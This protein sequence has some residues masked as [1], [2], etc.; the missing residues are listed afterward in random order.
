MRPTARL[1]GVA[2]LFWIGTSAAVAAESGRLKSA[3]TALFTD[4]WVGGDAA[5]F[6]A[7]GHLSHAKDA[8]P[9]DAR[10]LY[11]YAL[12]QLKGHKF[13][14]ARAT[15][16]DLVQRFPNE[17]PARQTDVWLTA[18]LHDYPE[19]LTGLSALAARL[20]KE[21][22]ASSKDELAALE[23]AKFL[24]RM[25]GFLAGPAPDHLP[26][27]KV[28]DAEKQVKD[29]LSSGRRVAFE[30]GR[31]EVT[32]KFNDLQAEKTSTQESSKV[33]EAKQKSDDQA[34]IAGDRESIK[35]ERATLE[36]QANAAKA[37]FDTEEKKLQEQIKPLKT[38]YDNLANRARPLQTKVQNAERDAAN[39]ES[40][41][42]GEKDK[43]KAQ[44]LRNDAKRIR[45][46]VQNDRRNLDQLQGQA[47]GLQGQFNHLEG[48]A[49][50]L[51]QQY[52]AGLSKLNAANNQLTNKERTIA[53][54]E[55]EDALPATGETGGV[56][57]LESKLTALATYVPLLLDQEKQRVL[58]SF[59]K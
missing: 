36:Q 43:N 1:T 53:Q 34:K 31:D 48:Q 39:K 30:A 29:G 54:R 2:I 26:D 44:Q 35:S 14:E 17:L 23:T 4:G 49:N 8:A 41:A 22:T 37:A 7:E 11:A 52:R 10:P 16:D 46:G 6:R 32:K 57:S 40:Q 18:Y 28:S 58:D 56:K 50:A 9:Q 19:A 42:N 51:A 24:G 21:D 3:V 13:K 55:R 47:R 45:D 15:L 25:F 33:D 38:E 59:E 12:V 27:D 5:L 20:P